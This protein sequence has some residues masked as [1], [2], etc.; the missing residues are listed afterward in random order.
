M[1]NSQRKHIG[2]LIGALLLF[3][4]GAAPVKASDEEKNLW[5]YFGANLGYTTVKPA[6]G[7]RESSRDGYAA[8]LKVL[9]SKYWEEWVADL[10]VGY[11]H[12]MASGSDQFSPQADGTVRVKTRSA[13]IELSPRYRFGPSWQLGAVFNG[14]FGTD[15]AFDE[16]AVLNNSN[17]AL[18]G[19]ARVDYETPGQWHRWRFGAQIMHDL[20]VADR[21]VWWVMADIQFGLPVILGG[22]KTA[23]APAAP[24]ISPQTRPI[25]PRFAEVTPEK[26]V[27]IY[28]GEA[29]LRFKTASAELRPSSKQILEK[30]AQYLKKAPGAWM[31]MRVEG[32]ADKRGQFQYNQRLSKLRAEAVR[33]ELS[34]LGIPKKKLSA[35]GFGPVRPIDPAEDLEAYALNRRV[36]LSLDGV[37]DP[38]S[39]ARDLNDLE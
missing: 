11:Q 14:F 27:K 6:D 12:H 4:F 9:G 8:H 31:K 17:F 28:L 1:S 10:G 2:L 35:E 39:L 33:D 19:G 29:V 26:G 16:S 37:N 24:V 7:I 3:C 13:F 20:T 5:L 18:A 32:H 38:D 23:A 34:D 21:G 25:A 15:V 22:S 36:E 30:V